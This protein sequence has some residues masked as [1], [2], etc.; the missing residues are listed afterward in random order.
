MSRHPDNGKLKDDYC[1]NQRRNR[2]HNFRRLRFDAVSHSYPTR[3]SSVIPKE[4]LI[5]VASLR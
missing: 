5:S 2:R 1:Q 3:K 4:Q